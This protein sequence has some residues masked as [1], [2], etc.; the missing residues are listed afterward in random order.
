MTDDR[1]AL[2][3]ILD[4]PLGPGDEDP[5]QKKEAFVESVIQ[6]L[7]GP[8]TILGEQVCSQIEWGKKENKTKGIVRPEQER[9]DDVKKSFQGLAGRVD[10]RFF[11]RTQP[12]VKNPVLPPTDVVGP[13]EAYSKEK[14][15]FAIH[16]LP[17]GVGPPFRASL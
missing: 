3:F 10:F 7:E 11:H 14:A 8:L 4:A 15:L 1:I 12:E 16:P 9:N 5:G 6:S 13:H 2:D 17:L